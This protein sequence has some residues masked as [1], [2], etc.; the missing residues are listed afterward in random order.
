MNQLTTDIIVIGAGPVG[1]FTVFQAGMLGMRTV[2][3]DALP[4]IGGQC[5]ALYPEKPIYDIPG[6]PEISAGKL[7]EQLA[8]QASPFKPVYLLEQKAESLQKMANGFIVTTNAGH[9][10]MAKAVIVAAGCGAFVPNRPP[11]ANIESYEGQSVHY[12]VD[13]MNRFNN[14]RLVIAGGG[15][16]A[17]DWALNL[18]PI[19]EKIY[20]VHRRD[21]F[22][23][24]PDSIAKIYA[25]VE[26]KK[27]ELVIPYQLS[28]LHGENGKL[29]AVEVKDL[30]NR[31]LIIDADHLLAFFGL[32]MQLGSM[33]EWGLQMEDNHFFVHANN[34]QTNI[35]GIFA[36]GDVA[37]YPG[38][39]KLILTGFA[40]AALACH[41]CYE[42]VYPD[43]ALHFQYSTSKGVPLH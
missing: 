24:A 10:I 18:A 14:K 29:S 23:A 7:I 12:M 42:I 40:E 15:D 31:K 39:L 34:M 8:L 20:L 35:D 13:S 33:K 2:V 32:S 25:L 26:Q 6:Y 28:S 30:D 27:V 22:R 11:L 5:Q 43:K 3:I 21:K 9:K 37:R 16:S 17:I 38:K 19:A 4:Q 41:T 36:V 1:L